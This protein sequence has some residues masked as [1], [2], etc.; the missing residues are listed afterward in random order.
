MLRGQDQG[1]SGDR[2]FSVREEFPDA[3]YELNNPEAV[4]DEASR[5]RATLPMRREDF[6]PHITEL[7]VQQVSL[8]CL[9]KDGYTQELRIISLKHTAPGR[10]T[11]TAA[12]VRTTGG[13][14]G[15]R[16][17]SGAPWQVMI[18]QDPA[19]EWSIHLENTDFVRA[20]FKD[21]SLQDIVFVLT[22]AGVTPP[23]P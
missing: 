18:G 3:W 23:W 6:P 4:A 12:E 15:T 9:R 11:I 7:T 19:G 14:I 2:A 5:M 1:F 20:S 16:R 13:I 22:I 8:F 10:D 21:G 17:P